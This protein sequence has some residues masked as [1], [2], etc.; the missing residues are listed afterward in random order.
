MRPRLWLWILTLFLTLARPNTASAGETPVASSA[1]KTER[2]SCWPRTCSKLASGH[3]N[4][5]PQQFF[6]YGTAPYCGGD[7]PEE[8]GGV[9]CHLMNVYCDD[10]PGNGPAVWVFQR[11]QSRHPVGTPGA[12][13]AT[14]ISSPAGRPAGHRRRLPP[15]HARHAGPAHPA[16]G[17]PDPRDAP[18]YFEVEWPSAGFQ[19]GEDDILDPR[20]WFGMT[21]TIRPN[22]T[23]SPTTSAM[24]PSQGPTTSTGGP[25]PYRRHRP[26]FM[27]TP[28]PTGPPTPS[29]AAM[30]P[31]MTQSGSRSRAR[32]PSWAHPEGASASPRRCNPLSPG[33]LTHSAASSP[34]LR[35]VCRP[36]PHRPF[37]HLL[38]REPTDRR[39]PHG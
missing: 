6:D 18:T 7:I 10:F 34:R 21:I 5:T 4:G 30:S 2:H 28:A 36:I 1:F 22:S 11:H 23:P 14:P 37:P 17:Q 20:D 15:H 25:Y 8:P 33:R 31:S 3:V 27:P 24:A 35:P 26:H 12:T 9:D 38:F 16:R 13:P 29:I 19:P 39:R 32:W